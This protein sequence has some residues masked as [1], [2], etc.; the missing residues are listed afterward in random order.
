[1]IALLD[2]SV[3]GGVARLVLNR[4][5]R[6]NAFDDALKNAFAAGVDELATRGDLRVVVVAGAGRSF[7]S[8]ADLKMLG[9]LAPAAARS[10]MIEATLAF[11]RLERLPVPV[12]AA[13]HGYCLGGGFELALHCDFIIAAD[14]AQFGLPEAGIG[15]IPTAG[16]A[17]RLLA[18]VGAMRAREL[19]FSG[20]RLGA[21]EAARA[22]LV[23][24]LVPR[25]ELMARVDE[26]ARALAAAPPEG[27]AALK[28][29][30]VRRLE[31]DHAAGWISELE[32]FESLLRA[33]RS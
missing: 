29:L 14:D 1:M 19:L 6:H 33:R 21:D 5:E 17:E 23:A 10:F 2:V 25:A 11:R 22:G 13:V 15:L 7:S 3:D 8:G 31:R 16:A 30:V 28:A 4:P 18:T 27:I 26:R 9:A 32:A 12:I 20:R 24:D